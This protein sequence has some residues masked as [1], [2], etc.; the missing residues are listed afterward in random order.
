MSL[1]DILLDESLYELSLA[2]ATR[3]V[4]IKSGK[5]GINDAVDVCLDRSLL[6][7]RRMLSSRVQVS[8]Q[9]VDAAAQFVLGQLTISVNVQCIEDG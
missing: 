2:N 6:F 3:F 9:L 1:Q 5:D 7:S 4:S 8:Y